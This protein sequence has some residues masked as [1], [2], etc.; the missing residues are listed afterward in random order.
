MAEAAAAQAEA[1]YHSPQSGIKSPFSGPR[2]VPALAG[3][4]RLVVQIKAIEKGDLIL[5]WGKAADYGGGGG[6]RDEPRLL[7]TTSP[8]SSIKSP[9]LIALMCTTNRRIP[10][11]A[12]KNQGPETG[13]LILLR[14]LAMA[15][16]AAAGTNPERLAG[17]STLNPAGLPRS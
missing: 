7:A 6:G 2:F 13:D 11:S 9:V 14:L 15:E 1:S 10:A 8:Q 5:L 12:S 3:I 4:R 16:A 17:T